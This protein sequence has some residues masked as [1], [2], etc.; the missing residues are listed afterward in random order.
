MTNND[1]L[2]RVR[3]ALDLSDFSV[4]EMTKNGGRE[5]SSLDLTAYYRKEEE[6]GY[7]NCSNVVLNS[8]L[9]GLIIKKRGPRP[10]KNSE[11]SEPKKEPRKKITVPRNNDVIK[12]LKI[13]LE[14]KD[15]NMVEVFKSVDFKIS[16]SEINALFR[17]SDHKNF[18]EC[19]DQILRNFIQGLAKAYR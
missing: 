4:L 8:F 2:K 19:G 17:R 14:L 10:D 7:K 15:D 3:Y 5:I 13:A 11:T 18:R 16:K 1:I 6:E 9:D 12:K